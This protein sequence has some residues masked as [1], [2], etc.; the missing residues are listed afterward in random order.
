MNIYQNHHFSDKKSHEIPMNHPLNAM[1]NPYDAM[2]LQ[3]PHF[4]LGYLQAISRLA[5]QLGSGPQSP[6]PTT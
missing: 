6:G 3:P 4:Y 2:M 5:H 1:K